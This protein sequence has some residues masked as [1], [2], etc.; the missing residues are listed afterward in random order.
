MSEEST[1]Y[2]QAERQAAMMNKMTL[3][4]SSP[5]DFMRTKEESTN[6]SIDTYLEYKRLVEE[7]SDE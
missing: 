7:D 1:T 3:F 6:E 5:S 2:Q 4:H